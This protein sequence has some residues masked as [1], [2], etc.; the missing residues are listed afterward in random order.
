MNIYEYE[1]A[2]IATS[3]YKTSVESLFVV[4]VAMVGEVGEYANKIKKASFKETLDNPF[5]VDDLKSELGDV[6]WYLTE[7]CHQHGLSLDDVAMCNAKKV[8][9]RKNKGL[10]YNQ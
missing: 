9:E 2:V 10:T 6:L 5:V 4:T 7:L 1:Q 8:T 3:N